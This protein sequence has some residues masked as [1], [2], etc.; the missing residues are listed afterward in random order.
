MMPGT[1]SR[2]SAPTTP[3]STSWPTC[4]PAAGRHAS[5]D[6][7]CTSCKSRR[8]WWR[9]RMAVA[10]TA[11]SRSM[12]PPPPRPRRAAAGDR[13]GAA[14]AHRPGSDAA[15]GGAGPE[16]LR[17]AVPVADG[18]RGRLRRQG[19][20]IE[21][22]QL[23]RRD[24]R[25]LRKGPRAL[26]PGDAGGG[27]ARRAD[28]SDRC[29]PC[30]AQCGAP[31]K[32]RARGERK[33]DAMRRTLGVLTLSLTA[34]PVFGLSA[35]GVDRTKPPAL[36]APPAL[37]LP[38]VQT[39]TLPNGLMLAVVEM[40]KVPVVDVQLLLDAGAARD[41]SGV[42]GLATFTATMLQQGAGARSALDVADEAAFLGAQL[43][44]TA[45]FDG[46]SASIHVP[47]R[48]LE[49][50]LDLLADVVLR[51]SF[52]D[53]EIARQRELRAAQLVQQ[54]DEPVAVANIAFPAIVYGREHPYGHP[55]NGTDSA[56]ARLA[57]EPVT[58]FY[59]T[60]YRPNG[61]RLLIVGDVTLVEV[62]RLAAA[63]FGGWERGEVPAFPSP[64]APAPAATRTVYLIDKPGAAQSVV[65]IGHAG[66]ARTTPD[67]FA[68]EVLNT[69][70][71]GAFTSRLNQNL[72][73]THGYTYGAF[74]QFPPR[75]LT[76][77]FVA[78]ASVVTAKTDSSLIEFL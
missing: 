9:S 77:A 72:R 78:L 67:W 54:R 34:W 27:P 68:L 59:R 51:P 29:S 35:Q 52:A 26:P 73:E 61:A 15:G 38:A 40:H 25:L 7:W 19:R 48:R 75:R 3:R 71:G 37:K 13:R 66:P 74:S 62:R 10:S 33:V 28:V 46:A 22:L 31:G 30:G 23:L 70:V 17:G 2:R 65:R 20:S 11:N 39:T 16:H 36:P 55:L 53:S 50:G 1:R 60:Y 4:S 64:P 24:S 69:I 8:T 18:A 12:P 14:E 44:T 47:K 5:I 45:S 58:E 43:G 21:L 6:G 32:A 41:P 63:R 57:R 76:G 42:P 56:T 49:A